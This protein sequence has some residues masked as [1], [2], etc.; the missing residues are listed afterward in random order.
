M[1]PELALS[2]WNNFHSGAV[3]VVE[4]VVTITVCQKREKGIETTWFAF[5]DCDHTNTTCFNVGARGCCMLWRRC[6]CLFWRLGMGWD[7]HCRDH[8]I[9]IYCEK[10]RVV[11]FSSGKLSERFLWICTQYKISNGKRICFV[12]FFCQKN[13]IQNINSKKHNRLQPATLAQK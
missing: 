8:P 1:L 7:S 3:E 4:P 5:V 6:L 11:N 13:I 12:T 2:V 9:Y 10:N